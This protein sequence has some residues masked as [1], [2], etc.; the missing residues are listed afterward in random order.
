[1]KPGSALRLSDVAGSTALARCVDCGA[2]LY[3]LAESDIE[4][5]CR[6]R[7]GV[8]ERRCVDAWMTRL[9]AAA[10]GRRHER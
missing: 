2:E 6:P 10:L 8:N 3:A 5:R 1:M 9:R 7:P 4:Y